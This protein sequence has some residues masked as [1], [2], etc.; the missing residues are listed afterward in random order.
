MK[1]SLTLIELTKHNTGQGVDRFEH[2]P[3]MMQISLTIRP[4]FVHQ[5]LRRT[6]KCPWDRIDRLCLLKERRSVCIHLFV[7]IFSRVA[8]DVQAN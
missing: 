6:S 2:Y 8:E 3:L 4:R 1:T 7:Q 5:L